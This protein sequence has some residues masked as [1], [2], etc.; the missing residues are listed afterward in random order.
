M[1]SV[2]SAI[3]AAELSLQGV[4]AENSVGNRT[5]LDV[6]NARQELLNSRVQLVVTRRDAYVAAFSVLAA[7]GR[8]DARELGLDVSTLDDPA[9][10]YARVGGKL[11]DFSFDPNPTATASRTIALPAQDATPIAVRGGQ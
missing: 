10:N 11:L 6:L 5:I 1:S 2:Q 7:M 8:A 4:E 9:A 3:R